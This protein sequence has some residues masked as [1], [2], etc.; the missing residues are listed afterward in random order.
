MKCSSFE[1]F[2][3]LKFTEYCFKFKIFLLHKESVANLPSISFKNVGTN[4]VVLKQ[5]LLQNNSMLSL[6]ESES[7]RKI[8]KL[9]V[10]D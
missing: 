4:T 5:C 3:L 10:S 8:S 1:T 7:L 2:K 6:T 9:I